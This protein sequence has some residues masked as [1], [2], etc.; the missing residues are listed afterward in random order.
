MLS[1][2]QSDKKLPSRTRWLS[3]TVWGIAISSLFSD[4][5]HESAT[6]ILPMF[7]ASIGAAPIALG[8]I[9]GCADAFSSFAKLGS[10][11]FSDRLHRRKPIAVTGYF[12]TA[13]AT[14][15]F[16]IAA[17]WFHVLFGRSL[18][19][20]GR[21]IRG[22]VRDAILT[23]AIPPDTR[24]KA[25]GF[26]RAMDTAGAVLGPVAALW[27]VSFMPFRTIF[28]LTLIPGM[29][30]AASF[31]F[32]V[33][34]RRRDILPEP[35]NFIMSIA[36]L[37]AEYRRYLL[38]VGL[39]GIG[40]F[41]HTLLILRATQILAG[42]GYSNAAF[43][44]VS[45]YTIHNIVYALASYPAGALGDR[46]GKK[47]FLV[48]GYG[49][50]AV[51]CAGFILAPASYATLVILFGVAGIYIAI[52]DALE[53]AVA[54][55]LIQPQLRGTGFGMLATVNGLGDFISSIVVGTLWTA[56]SPAAGFLFAGIFSLAGMLLLLRIRNR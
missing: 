26:D 41:S 5:S 50:S 28:L 29:L 11:W 20:F 4:L 32:V 33:Q 15:T 49:L 23:D 31:A 38:A 16:A 8:I 42:S 54:A 37:P 48:I 55:D 30:A 3:R 7:L 22:P 13:S 27:L 12:L 17:Q 35:K 2:N 39:F 51:M 6:A 44:A 18:A 52:E 43:L 56:V 45:L 9:E 46:L 24:G 14:A 34:E 1:E 19:W 10:G 21:G 25:F 47:G 40:D 36:A 53:R